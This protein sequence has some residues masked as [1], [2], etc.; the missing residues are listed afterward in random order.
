MKTKTQQPP[1][2]SGTKRF[3]A[4]YDIHIGWEWHVSGGRRS[5]RNTHNPAAL[6]LALQFVQDFA[7]DIVIL[8]G[9]QIN[10]GP[11][12][13]WSKGKPRLSESFRLKRELDKLSELVLEPL[14]AAA[15]KIWLDGNHE[16]W[17][18]QLVDENPGIEGLVEPRGYLGLAK[19]G[20]AHRSQ[21][22]M[23]KLGKLHFVHG[24]VAL[25]Q[26]EYSNPA[27]V[28]VQAYN[29]NIRAGHLHT[30]SAYTQV[31]PTDRQDYHTGIVVP[32][33]SSR[34]PYY[35]KYNPSNFLN[36]FL[37][38]WV[39]RDGSFTDYVATI[40]YNRMVVNGKLYR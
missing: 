14:K 37:Y 16:A 28:L 30:Y 2:D 36:G 18:E 7:P 39:H 8:G 29:R 4:L 19:Q 13:H 33:L 22:E 21:G 9:D 25:K 20:W 38:G 15:V 23:Y 3:V 27:K 40:N 11:V 12:S 31:T 26:R 34:A 10:C 6:K 35:A 5:V 32:A 1:T 24:D 17:I